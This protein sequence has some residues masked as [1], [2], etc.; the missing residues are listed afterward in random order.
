MALIGDS[1]F[2]DWEAIQAMDEILPRY[3]ADLIRDAAE[4]EHEGEY[5]AAEMC[6]EAAGYG[7]L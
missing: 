4:F 7:G 6:R 5:E 2:Q 1:P 3:E